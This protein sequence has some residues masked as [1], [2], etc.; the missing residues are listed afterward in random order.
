MIVSHM[1]R[2]ALSGAPSPSRG[3]GSVEAAAVEMTSFEEFYRA[4]RDRLAR[5][6]ALTL[7]DA[8]LGAEATD[9]AF[10]RACQRWPDVCAYRNP[11][12]WVYRVALN[13][14]RSWLRRKRREK[15]KEPLVAV[16]ETS[17]DAAMDVDLERAIGEL[18][19]DHRDVVVGRYFM[20]WSVSETADALGIAPGTVKSR[21]S[22]AL[23]Q[24]HAALEGDRL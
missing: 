16:D 1:E 14:A 19:R 17:T 21:L 2:D 7:R 22:R 23:D 9:E 15:D 13:W 4:H 11:E 24:L 3:Q 20:G 6:L 8:E 10:A 12:G 5:A 18:S